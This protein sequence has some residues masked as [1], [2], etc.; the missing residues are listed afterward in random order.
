MSRKRVHDGSRPRLGRALP[1]ARRA[2]LSMSRDIFPDYQNPW[3]AKVTAQPEENYAIKAV[4]RSRKLSEAIYEQDEVLTALYKVPKNA[5][6][7]EF[8][9]SQVVADI[10][11]ELSRFDRPAV[12]LGE[13]DAEESV[14]QLDIC[15]WDGFKGT[16]CCFLSV[17][18][19]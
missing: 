8:M 2:T 5:A 11:T 16:D 19:T 4:S 15:T 10:R 17:G 18:I 7:T 3:T 12:G 9:R 14:D 1:G 6:A 13:F